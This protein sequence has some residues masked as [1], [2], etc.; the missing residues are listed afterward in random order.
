MILVDDRC[1]NC[2]GK[3]KDVLHA[4]WSCPCLSQVRSQD[5]TWNYNTKP[6]FLSFQALVENIIE[7]WTDLN[8]F[9][10]MVYA[11]WYRINAIKTSN[12]QSNMFLWKCR[13]PKHLLFEPFL[14]AP[15]LTSW[16]A[17]W[18][19]WKPP[20]WSK[21]KVNFDGSVY[22]ESKLAGARVIV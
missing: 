5:S 3:I 16:S 19:I 15:D 14:G 2:N 13:E 17:P 6:Q 4:L 11:I 7:T 8:L 20:P 10:T 18:P 21:L 1:E 22:R 9:A 12:Y